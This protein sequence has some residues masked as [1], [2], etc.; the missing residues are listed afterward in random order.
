MDG[1]IPEREAME[2]PV[3]HRAGEFQEHHNFTHWLMELNGVT[4]RTGMKCF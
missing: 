3:G 4:V 2:H 1:Q